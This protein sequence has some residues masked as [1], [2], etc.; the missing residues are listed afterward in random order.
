MHRPA[1]Q[2]CLPP[3][4]LQVQSTGYTTAAAATT[5]AGL[6]REHGLQ[7][8]LMERRLCPG[9]LHPRNQD[10]QQHDEGDYHRA[11]DGDAGDGARRGPRCCCDGARG[12]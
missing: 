11:A 8:L 9:V 10:A 7:H 6:R 1:L 4:R 2:N 12:P 5:I 3:Q